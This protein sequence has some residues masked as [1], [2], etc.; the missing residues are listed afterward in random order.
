MGEDVLDRGPLTRVVQAPQLRLQLGTAIKD[1]E[2]EV[3]VQMERVGSE[4]EAH[5]PRQAGP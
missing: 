5:L 1:G 2:R 4:T 3:V